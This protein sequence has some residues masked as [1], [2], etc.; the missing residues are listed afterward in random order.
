MCE[1]CI[2]STE[3]GDLHV[4]WLMG[5]GIAAQPHLNTFVRYEVCISWRFT[6]GA[7]CSV[8]AL[9]WNAERTVLANSFRRHDWSHVS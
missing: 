1:G 8:A 4:A 5:A 3:F 9:R 2:A 7:V 6:L